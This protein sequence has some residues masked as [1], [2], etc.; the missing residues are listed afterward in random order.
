[1]NSM[2][3]SN[4]WKTSLYYLFLLYF[5]LRIFPLQTFSVKFYSSQYLFPG[6]WFPSSCWLT[7]QNIKHCLQTPAHLELLICVS[8][9]PSFTR[10]L[11]HQNEQGQGTEEGWGVLQ[12]S[13]RS[14]M[15]CTMGAGSRSNCG[16]SCFCERVN[17][18]SEWGL[19]FQEMVWLKHISFLSMFEA[20]F[21]YCSALAAVESI[22][23]TQT[24]V[25]LRQEI[26]M[27]L[28]RKR[29]FPIFFILSN[30]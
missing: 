1:M 20:L 6:I 14:A 30:G 3:E 9:L 15:C 25:P 29:R 17:G 28:K 11:L 24:Q 4:F 18:E 27:S 13:L 19:E 7:L 10:A 23:T 26:K 12:Q 2:V 21:L 8:N 16:L 5:H 22:W